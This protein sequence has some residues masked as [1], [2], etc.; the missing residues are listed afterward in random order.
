MEEWG[1]RFDMKIHLHH[2]PFQIEKF[3]FAQEICQ[4][5]TDKWRG[6]NQER[7]RV[8]ELWVRDRIDPNQENPQSSNSAHVRT[9]ILH[10]GTMKRFGG[11]TRLTAWTVEWNSLPPIL[12]IGPTIYALRRCHAVTAAR[13]RDIY[14]W[15]LF[16]L[17]ERERDG[18][19]FI[20]LEQ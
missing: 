14:N 2:F 7:R 5:H 16:N 3:A 6:N 17:Q 19:W 12:R 8:G 13:F 9:Y 4:L 1:I 15:P 20:E 18:Q 11:A 10:R